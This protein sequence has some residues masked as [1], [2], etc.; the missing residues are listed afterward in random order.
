M[1]VVQRAHGDEFIRAFLSLDQLRNDHRERIFLVIQRVVQEIPTHFL[2][3]VKFVL[4]I[5]HIVQDIEKP[6]RADFD[7]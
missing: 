5:G 4:H 6:V 1:R 7:G 2:Y 3:S